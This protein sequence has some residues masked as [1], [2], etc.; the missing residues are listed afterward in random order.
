VVEGFLSF[1][2]EE[3]QCSEGFQA[4]HFAK[5]AAAEA[6]NFWFRSRNQL[7]IWAI[8]RFFPTARN[9]CEIG[10]G[11]GFVLSGVKI[12]C[13]SLL[14]CGSEIFSTGLG[15]AKERLENVELYQMD[16]RRIPFV[17]E[18]DVIG[19]F[20]VLEHITEDERVLREIYKALKPE[21]GII[22]T[23]PQHQFLW[24]P[25]DEL[26]CHVRRYEALEVKEKLISA[27][28]SVKRMTSFVSLL[29][30]LM[31]ASRLWQS[32]RKEC[33]NEM[34]ELQISGWKNTVLEQVLDIERRLIKLGLNFPV[35]GSLL[36]V[37][38]KDNA[39]C[40]SPLN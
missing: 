2:P 34:A 11:T 1:A 24:S 40:Q 26:A 33:V 7:I 5:L 29:F 16:A 13:P 35:G 32:Q 17:D 10:C 12:A 15:F 30:P 27:G 18:F 8:Q 23:V 19:A 38:K 39:S 4:S 25:T 20:D 9:F 36:A 22:L 28:F 21:G 14:L 37:A 31:V 6:G 3:S